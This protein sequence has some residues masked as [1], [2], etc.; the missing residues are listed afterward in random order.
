VNA[1]AGALRVALTVSV[2]E[3]DPVIETGLKLALVRGGSL[4]T[5][6]LTAPA[7][8]LPATIPTYSAR[9]IRAKQSGGQGRR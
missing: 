2:E 5:L 3:P 6:R 1:L 8:S 7:N 4:L 9:W